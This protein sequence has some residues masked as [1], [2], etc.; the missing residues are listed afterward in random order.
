MSKV[1]KIEF[2]LNYENNTKV[3]DL[4]L[5][6]KVNGNVTKEY[7]Y[8]AL[9]IYKMNDSVGSLCSIGDSE[10]KLD[11]SYVLNND[12]EY[13][14]S[15]QELAINNME[16][17]DTLWHTDGNVFVNEKDIETYGKY[18]LGSKYENNISESFTFIMPKGTVVKK[19][20]VNKIE[21]VLNYENN[22]KV[23][24]LKLEVKVNGNVTK[25]YTYESLK[26][27]KANNNLASVCNIDETQTK[28]DGNYA[29]NNG[30]EYIIRIEELAINNMEYN[31]MVWHSDGNVL[32][33]G[34]A[35][36]SYGKYCMG[37]KY[38]NNISE[39]F[40]FVIPKGT[41]VEKA[42]VNKIEFVLNYE[43]NTKV[44]DLKLEVKVN[45]NVTKEY[46][47]EALNI[48]KMNDSVGSLCS[49]GD[50]ETKLD[51]SYVLNNDEEYAISIQE[52]TIN[53]MEYNSMVWHSDGN[54]FV[55]GKIVDSYGK[56]CLGSKYENNTSESFSFILPKGVANT[57]EQPEENEQVENETTEVIVQ[58]NN[59]NNNNN[60]SQNDIILP[61]CIGI[62]VLIILVSSFIILK[63]RKS[64][65]AEINNETF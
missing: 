65:K 42:Q 26:I 27:Y 8:E 40:T 53:N 57:N 3:S 29:L 34:K 48:Y 47:Y 21:F 52:L 37:S 13:A 61:I 58:E 19:A 16:Y 55:N 46:T 2:V 11:G 56:Y 15:I 4:K 30:E 31:S 38:E 49:I 44:S 7:T 14:I 10:T 18:C 51:S 20:Q 23:S 36:D 24:D 39:S 12:E 50:S 59:I 54:V 25:E 64:K 17:N 45:G 28:L 33:N 63:K 41:V 6:V 1:N 9:N 22:T 62:G 5:E 43:N 60:N 35:M 32:V